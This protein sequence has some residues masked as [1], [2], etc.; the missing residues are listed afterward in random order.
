MILTLIVLSL[1][2]LQAFGASSIRIGVLFPEYLPQ[3]GGGFGGS[4]YG[5]MYDGAQ[6]AASEINAAGGINVSGTMEN[7]VLDLQDEGAYDPTL[8]PPNYNTAITLAS[9]TEMLTSG[10]QFI[11]GGSRTETTTAALSTLQAWNTGGNTPVPFFICGAATNSLININ[12]TENPGGQWVFRGTPV[13]DTQLLYTLANYLKQYLIPKLAK[14]YTNT[15]SPPETPGQLRFAVVAE[16]LPWTQMLA[17]F[18]TA[19]AGYPGTPGYNYFLGPNVTTSGVTGT[20]GSPVLPGKNIVP[21]TGYDFTPLVS[22]LNS[23]NVHLIIDLFTMPEVNGLIH[24][25]KAANMPAM[26]VGIDVPGQQQS[27]WADTGSSEYE[28]AL[29]YSGTATP[30]VPGYSDVF[31]RNFCSFSKGE[32]GGVQSYWP[33]YTAAGAYD[34]IYGIKLAIE[35]AGTSDANDPALLAAIQATNRTGLTG[36]FM[37]TSNDVYCNSTGV[38]WTRYDAQPYGCARGEMVQW[39]Q[40]TTVP[41]SPYPNVGAQ[42]NVVS[43]TDQLYS[44]KTQIPPYMYPLSLRDINLDGRVDIQDIAI[45]G[46]A[47]GTKPGE[48]NWNMEA[49]ANLDGKVDY[50]DL[51]IVEGVTAVD[52]V[53][54]ENLTSAKTVIGQGYCGNLTVT[55]QNLGNIPE[56]FNVTV[57]ANTIALNTLNFSLAIGG[58]AT[59]EFVWNTTGFAYG[60]YTL[61]AAADVVQYEQNTANNNCTDG[62]VTVTIPGD[63]NGDFNVSLS[64]LVLLANAYGSVPGDS[65]WNPN[66]DINGDGKASLQD[67]VIM[68]NH[69][70]QH[71]P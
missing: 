61:K 53:A 51:Y 15:T 7:I 44:R 5:G 22:I 52:D 62:V 60:N 68:A 33:L 14:I 55:P 41:A 31:F 32:S 42:I 71:Y 20:G 9:M 39:I 49:D 36:Q 1:S 70:G 35:N 26:V 59:E 34:A 37:Y 54:V 38:S 17:Y 63:L 4:G 43:P 24:A 66:A 30:I 18:L 19:P 69:Y 29:C 46:R 8:I 23:Q 57:Y 48:A 47:M 10:D 2:A 6:M 58:N 21:A 27:H 56:D 16:D 3:G 25:V 45:V 50:R 64:D 12:Q 40:N 11:V 28:V 67:L 65:K 13:N